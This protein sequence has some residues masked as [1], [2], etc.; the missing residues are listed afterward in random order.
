MLITKA[1][2]QWSKW[3][4]R[5]SLGRIS[6]LLGADSDIHFSTC[7]TVPPE[8]RI[9]NLESNGIFALANGNNRIW[10]IIGPILAAFCLGVVTG[11]ETLGIGM[12]ELN[13]RPSQMEGSSLGF[14][15]LSGLGVALISEGRSHSEM[16][17][18]QSAFARM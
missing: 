12:E 4:K 1:A 17:A 18:C 9:E 10:G 16:L 6:L 3:R 14:T 7:A 5:I 11:L 2:F 8:F 13:Q 15:V